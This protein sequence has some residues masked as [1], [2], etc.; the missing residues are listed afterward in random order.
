[1]GSINIIATVM[2]MRAP[3]MTYMKMPLFVWTWLITAFLLIMVMPV[4]AGAGSETLDLSTLRGKVVY[5]DFWASWCG[6]CRLLEPMIEEMARRL[7]I[8]AFGVAND[9]QIASLCKDV[10][11]DRSD[12]P[13]MNVTL[14]KLMTETQAHTH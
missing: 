7:S 8:L 3:G 4:L 1:M 9:E 12:R 14:A 5:V 2:N 13:D 6:P 11:N 10:A